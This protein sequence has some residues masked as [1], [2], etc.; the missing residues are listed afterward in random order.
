MGEGQRESKMER[1]QIGNQMERKA[2]EELLESEIKRDISRDSGMK[3][4]MERRE[5]WRD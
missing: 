1:G 3:R 4:E 5:A 2:D